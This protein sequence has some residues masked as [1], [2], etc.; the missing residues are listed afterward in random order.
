MIHEPHSCKVHTCIKAKL[1]KFE[2]I[3]PTMKVPGIWL[4]N[5]PAE[6]EIVLLGTGLGVFERTNEDSAKKRY[7][8]VVNH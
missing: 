5:E 4:L 6:L 7:H 1:H 3:F 2:Y 8:V